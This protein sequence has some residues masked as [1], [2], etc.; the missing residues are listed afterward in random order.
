[1]APLVAQLSVINTEFVYVPP[2]GAII[3]VATVA[4]ITMVKLALATA[5][6]IEPALTAFALTVS[7]FVTVNALADTVELLVG[8]LPSAV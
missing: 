4:G 3:G 8:V 1:M 5:L 7:E 6:S 2:A